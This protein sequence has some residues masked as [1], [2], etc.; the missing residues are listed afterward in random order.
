M[1]HIIFRFIF[2]GINVL[3]LFVIAKVLT[4]DYKPRLKDTVYIVTASLLCATVFSIAFD[5][6]IHSDTLFASFYVIGYLL[7][8]FFYVHKLTARSVKKSIIIAIFAEFF[9]TIVFLSVHAVI[10]LFFTPMRVRY[11]TFEQALLLIPYVLLLIIFSVAIA[12]F[13]VKATVKLRKFLNNNDAI[14]T[15]LLIGSVLTYLIVN[16]ITTLGV[17]VGDNLLLSDW[18]YTLLISGYSIAMVLSFFAYSKFIRT[19][20]TLQQEQRER[21]ILQYYTKELE[22]QQL[23][24]RKFK[25]DQENLFSTLD[26]YMHEKDWDGLTEF[27][28]QVRDASEAITHREFALEDLSN[29]KV[30]EFKNILTAKL[31]MAQ[32]LG[33]NVTFEAGNEINDIP[34]KLVALVRMV[35]II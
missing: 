13:V 28:S 9:S 25:H 4:Q 26:V 10:H 34:I 21:E 16:A 23:I 2:F 19:K 29:I 11:W 18:F 3:S 27:Y 6:R 1:S 33:L 20:H 12:L 35:G 14:Q 15:M 5:M 7:L 17:N 32:Q 8:V 30:Q 22:E 24:I 31:T